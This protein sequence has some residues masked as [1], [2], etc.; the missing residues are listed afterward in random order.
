VVLANLGYLGHMWELYAMWAWVPVFL[1]S[2]FAL[3]G[4]GAESASLAAFAVIG[5]GGLSCVLAGKLADRLGR[6]TITIASMAVS[7]ACALLVGLLYG[8][9]PALLVVLCL[10]WGFA[11]IADSAQFSACVSELAQSQYIGTALT[12]QTS[13]GFLLTTVTIRLIPTLEKQVGWQWAF[14]FLAI[15][16]ALGVVAMWALRRLPEAGKLAGGKG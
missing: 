13:L 3:V 4:V 1:L 15:G 10:V 8:G 7:G 11:V 14:A 2:S 12:L 16:P 9:N 5:I 6:T